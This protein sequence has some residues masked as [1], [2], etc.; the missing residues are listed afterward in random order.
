MMEVSSI[1]V[2]QLEAVIKTKMAADHGLGISLLERLMKLPAYSLTKGDPR[3]LTMLVRN[4]RSHGALLTVPSRLFY[5]GRLLPCANQVSVKHLT[6]NQIPAIQETT[7]TSVPS[8]G[9]PL[10]AVQGR[11]G[12]A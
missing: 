2:P 9:C 12:P 7:Y 4:F 1:I 6:M 3:L 10:R 8:L 11:L 5:E